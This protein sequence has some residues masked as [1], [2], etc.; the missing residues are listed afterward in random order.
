MRVLLE[1]FPKRKL[2]SKLASRASVNLAAGYS[3]VV[4]LEEEAGPARP[5]QT[6]A[7]NDAAC[8]SRWFPAW[9]RRSRYAAATTKLAI[10][11]VQ[12][13]RLSQSTFLRQM[14]AGSSYGLDGRTRPHIRWILK[15]RGIDTA[16]RKP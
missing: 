13:S 1:Q 10:S 11:A 14:A 5:G 16:L 8:L 4:T 2:T 3:A 12:G 6:P 7:R 9:A 15:V